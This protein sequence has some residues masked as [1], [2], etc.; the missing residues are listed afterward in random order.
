MLRRLS[1]FLAGA[2]L[3]S[4]AFA[5]SV[6]NGGITTNQIWTTAQWINAW[7]TKVDVSQL[8]VTIP[9]YPLTAA[10]ISLSIT[11]SNFAYP[12]GNV[13]RYGA[14]PTGGVDSTVAIQLAINVIGAG[15]G[16]FV[17]LGA[18][19]F[20]TSSTLVVGNGTTTTPSTVNNVF[21]QASGSSSPFASGAN[22]TRILWNG[23]AGGTILQF[24]GAGVGGGIS[25]S[26]LLDGNGTA[27]TGLYLLH[28]VAGHFQTV[29][30]KN[31]TGKY[32][33]LFTQTV[34]DTVGG[35]RDNIF[36][37]YFTDTIPSGATGLSID[38]LTTT[39]DA[40][41]NTF[42]MIDIPLSGS[43][44]TGI[45]LGYADF[46]DFRVVDLSVQSTLTSSVGISLVGGG[47]TGN[48]IFPSLNRFGQLATSAPIV[49]NTSAGTPYGNYV[50]LFDLADSN[51]VIPT[52]V[53]LYGTTAGL[54]GG[55]Q[56]TQTFGS[57][58]VATDFV[59]AGT[60]GTYALET[61]GSATSG[62][63]FGLLVNAGTTS[64]D[65]ALDVCNQAN[66]SCFLQIRG[67]GSIVTSGQTDQGPGAISAAAFYSANVQLK[68]NLS[69]TTSAIGGSSIANGTC[70]S[71]TVSVAGAATTMAVQAT[72]GAFP[73]A[74][75]YWAG[76]VSSAGTVTVEVCNATGATNSPTGVAYNVR[77]L[78]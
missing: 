16:G 17:T 70:A 23:G 36:G 61:S 69:A 57:G 24:M 14:D 37:L 60:A 29:G 26:I 48:A 3:C 75:F 44:A 32:L 35:V 52:A 39:A 31:C 51:N 78:Q 18:G 21:I 56:R 50:A 9:T 2:L 65:N 5:Q 68:P 72:P 27:A 64:A 74:G 58:S 34:P 19:T 6:P 55:V 10:E 12:V 15:N 76:Y 8:G 13:L 20:K 43:G 22:G 45:S 28:W 66:T 73:G 41:Q 63:S 53:G 30:I 25:G 59:T 54:I 49:S 46:N 38:A 71:G 4:F 7:Q 47:P 77:V 40:L 33:K 1:A 67:D 42:D 11:P 62:Q